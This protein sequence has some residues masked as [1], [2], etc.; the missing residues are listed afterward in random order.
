MNQK[1][2][3]DNN[4][5]TPEEAAQQLRISP[6]TLNKWRSVGRGNINF[7]KIGRCVRYR[8]SDIQDYI[9]RNIKGAAA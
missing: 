8:A 9:E 3:L 5:L 6:R 7:V 2:A 4:L 1:R